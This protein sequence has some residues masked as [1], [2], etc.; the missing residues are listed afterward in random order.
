MLLL[1]P[2]IKPT[3][4]VCHLSHLMDWTII[5][6][7]FYL[8]IHYYW[9]IWD[10]FYILVTERKE[11]KEGKNVKLLPKEWYLLHQQ[12]RIGASLS[13]TKSPYVREPILTKLLFFDW[14]LN[15]IICA[16]IPFMKCM[17]QLNCPIP[18]EILQ[19]CTT[20]LAYKWS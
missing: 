11:K 5:F 10:I 17:N 9:W 7:Q 8:T 1:S 14:N 12:V 16:L 18:F 15:K 3:N 13:T 19:I 2:H 20:T 4:I 6:N